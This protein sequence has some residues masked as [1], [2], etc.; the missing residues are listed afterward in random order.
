MTS[1]NVSKTAIRRL[2][3]GVALSAAMSAAAVAAP[4][5]SNDYSSNLSMADRVMTLR[6]S[7]SGS[8]DA[9]EI[10]SASVEL[11]KMVGTMT[12]WTKTDRQVQI[13]E[14]DRPNPGDVA[15]VPLPAA[16]WL[17]LGGIGGLAALR[18]R[19]G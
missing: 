6:Q 16:G 17:L 12:N 19:K 8:P 11:V 13:V 3:A 4:V 18:R 7:L 5:P 14:E 1:Q 10:A 2:V 9:S 15:V